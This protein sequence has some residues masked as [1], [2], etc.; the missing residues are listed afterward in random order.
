MCAYSSS[1]SLLQVT[2]F[3]LGESFLL[4]VPMSDPT[5][6]DRQ[7]VVI[8]HL[9]RSLCGRGTGKC[10][11]SAPTLVALPHSAVW[12][13]SMHAAVSWSLPLEDEPVVLDTWYQWKEATRASM[14]GLARNDADGSVAGAPWRWTS[15]QGWAARMQLFLPHMPAFRPYVNSAEHHSESK[16]WKAGPP[17]KAGEET[18]HDG[19]GWRAGKPRSHRLVLPITNTSPDGPRKRLPVKQ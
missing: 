19:W 10:Q 4:K 15:I 11:T 16:K 6:G 14:E 2:G 17:H 1:L 7:F 12:P 8:F 13:L 5:L 18:S 9:H 3:L